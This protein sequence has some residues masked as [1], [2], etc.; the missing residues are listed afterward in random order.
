[1]LLAGDPETSSEF[2]SVVELAGIQTRVSRWIRENPTQR[3]QLLWSE[4]RRR[5][6]TKRRI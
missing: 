4:F 6:P 3:P 5:F 2:T 1:M